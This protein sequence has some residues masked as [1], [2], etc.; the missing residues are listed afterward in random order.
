MLITCPACGKVN[1]TGASAACARCGCDLA[2]LRV[3][4]EGAAWNLKESA[5]H[6]RAAN[7]SAA[8][9]NAEKSWG[10]HHSPRAAQAAFLAATALGQTE[11]IVLWR[12]CAATFLKS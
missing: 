1:E 11:A 6:L 8:L 5:R 4:I 7:W 3:I 10:L 2:A 12:D 9:S